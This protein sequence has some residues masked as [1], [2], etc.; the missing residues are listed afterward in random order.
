[1]TQGSNGHMLS[2]LELLKSATR[3]GKNVK[4]IAV[5]GSINAITTGEDAG[6]RIYD[7]EAWLPVN[8]ITFLVL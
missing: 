1:M 2:G 4:A 7:S 6:K 5:T 3:F 8:Y